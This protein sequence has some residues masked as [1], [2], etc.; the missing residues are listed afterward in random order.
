MTQLTLTNDVHKLI[1]DLLENEITE[2][3]D[4]ISNTDNLDFKNMLKEREAM[5]KK[6]QKDLQQAE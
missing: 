4:E 6:L 5:V 1:Q 3:R 2:L